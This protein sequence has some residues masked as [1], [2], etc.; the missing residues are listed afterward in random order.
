[1]RLQW[2]AIG[3]TLIVTFSTFGYPLLFDR[4]FI[5]LLVV[6]ALVSLKWDKNLFT[7]CVIFIGIYVAEEIAWF[8]SYDN[9]YFTMAANL[10]FILACWVSFYSKK[11]RISSVLAII[12][13]GA[14]FYWW[15]NEI[16]GPQ[17]SWSI[18]ICANL[19][20]AKH[21]VLL[22]PHFCSIR[23]A[24][25]SE[26]WEIT[27][28]DIDVGY[29]LSISLIHEFLNIVEYLFRHILSYPLMF[30]YDSYRF[31]AHALI[32]ILFYLF[33]RDFSETIRT[34]LFPA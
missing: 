29:I 15:L 17:I 25:Y 21:F 27:K 3:I 1:M 16:D 5:G 13:I 14:E 20:M 28:S 4:L 10:Y 7:L 23:L 2:L 19:L 31:I 26:E 11:G 12:V 22:R 8:L 34:K 18:F 32:A 30:V 9:Y 24:K 6:T 33:L